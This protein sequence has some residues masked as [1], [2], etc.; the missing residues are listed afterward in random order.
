MS[1]PN[2]LRSA[3]TTSTQATYCGP[4]HTTSLHHSIY[5]SIFE[6]FRKNEHVRALWNAAGQLLPDGV[7]AL[8][9]SVTAIIMSAHDHSEGGEWIWDH[10]VMSE[11]IWQAQSCEL[12]ATLDSLPLAAGFEI[13]RSLSEKL[14]RRV[15]VLQGGLPG[16]TGRLVESID[17]GVMECPAADCHCHDGTAQSACMITGP[18]QADKSRA[19]V[20]SM[21]GDGKSGGD[22]A[23]DAMQERLYVLVFASIERKLNLILHRHASELRA[24]SSYSV[25]DCRDAMIGEH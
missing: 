17:K 11:A 14:L 21:S 9:K 10:E 15:D 1:E 20:P 16:E 18:L 24:R 2:P 4:D 3:K 19:P 7:R 6:A 13:V 22:S 5:E 23:D 12:A 25:A 8:A